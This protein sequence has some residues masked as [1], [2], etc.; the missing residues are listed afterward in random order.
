MIQKLVNYYEKKRGES[1]VHWFNLLNFYV[2]PLITFIN[3]LISSYFFSKMFN[4][5]DD[6]LTIDPALFNKILVFIVSFGLWIIVPII[7]LLFK[8]FN[9]HRSNTMFLGSFML[10]NVFLTNLL[11]F[12]IG[13]FLIVSRNTA[14]GYKIKEKIL[15]SE[16]F[17]YLFHTIF[18]YLK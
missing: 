5:V 2:F 8:S 10:Y 15:K 17:N 1:P 13:F 14:F 11:P 7:G 4:P 9:V 16:S 3:V 12:Y 6:V 18:P